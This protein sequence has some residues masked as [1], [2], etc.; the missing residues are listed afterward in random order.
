M[1]F[2]EE[3]IPKEQLTEYYAQFDILA[4]PSLDEPFGMAVV[5]AM[6]CGLP[7]VAAD[8]GGLKDSVEN[9]LNGYRVPVQGIVGPL[10]VM[11]ENENL[12]REMGERSRLRAVEKFDN[13]LI[14]QKHVEIAEKG[15]L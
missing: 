14:A 12:R 4:A 2:D 7:V 1:T 6:A 11:V 5:E 9:G 3:A 15:G 8:E 13:R 10:T